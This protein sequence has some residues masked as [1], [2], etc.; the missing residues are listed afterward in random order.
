[1]VRSRGSPMTPAALSA[2]PSPGAGN[3]D[4][5]FARRQCQPT[6]LALPEWDAA[7]AADRC[8]CAT[9]DR[10]NWIRT[11]SHVFSRFRCIAC[12]YT[13][14]LSLFP[15]KYVHHVDLDLLVAS[16][17]SSSSFIPRFARLSSLERER[18]RGVGGRMFR[19]FVQ[20]SW[21]SAVIFDA[22]ENRVIFDR[23]RFLLGSI[24]L[25]CYGRG[26]ILVGW[27]MFFTCFFF[28]EWNLGNVIGL[29]RNSSCCSIVWIINSY[30]RVWV[31]R[32]FGVDFLKFRVA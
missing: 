26:D 32:G 27:K 19:R 14:T 7:L 25:E 4:L 3:C 18:E 29:V 22:K 6:T 10:E 21:V 30:R 17:S 12:L 13:R 15:S 28:L 9:P 1:M 16:S 2:Q 23:D 20:V 31:K 8:N 24:S 5:T 11:G